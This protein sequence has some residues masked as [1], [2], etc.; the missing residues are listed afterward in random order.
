MTR[1]IFDIETNGLL[2]EL[3]TVHSLVIKDFDTG[4][5]WSFK[6]NVIQEGLNL[7][8][9]ADEIIG[10]NI[11][12][13]DIPALQKLN[14]TFK[15]KGRA[16]D[17]L[18]LTRLFWPEIRDTDVN[19]VKRG[20]IPSKL[21]GR[22]SL[23]AYGYRLGKWK[24]DYSEVMKARGLDPWASWSQEMQDYCVQDVEVNSLLYEKCLKVWEGSDKNGLNIPYSDQ[25]VFL[26]LRVA[27]ILTRQEK[28]GFA[29]DV[30][31]AEKF[32]TTLIKEREELY[33]SLKKT[34]GSWWA[35]NGKTTV[36]KTRNV[37]RKDLPPIGTRLKRNGEMEKLYVKETYLEGSSHTKIKLTEFNPASNHHVADRLKKLRN[38][39][40]TEFTPSGDVKVDE[41]ILSQLVWPEAKLLTRYLTVSKRISQLAEGTQA[42]LKKERNGRIHG[43]V[44]SLGAVTRR[45]THSNPNV[46]QVP[47]VGS[48]FGAECRE[49]FTA[50]KGYVLVGCDADALELRCLAGYMAAYDAGEYIRTVLSGDK[51]VGTDM[52]SVN[53]R[54]LGLDPKKTYQ[55]D[56]KQ[57]DGRDIAK[58]WFYAFI[59]GA[60]DFKLGSVLGTQG[61][62]KVISGA[63]KA[64]RERFLTGLPALGKLV[65]TVQKRAFGYMK[66]VKDLSGQK[67]KEHV[68]GRGFVVGLD[69]GK[70]KVR[71]KHAALNTLLQSA[72]AIIM[73]KALIILDDDLQKEGLKPQIDYEFA[74]NIHDEWQLDVRQEHAEKISKIAEDSIRKAGEAFKFACPL[75]GQAAIGKNWKETH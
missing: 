4:Q 27:E 72:G 28:W 70:I 47:K 12:K 24:G 3:T 18:I 49:L 37:N 56:G 66:T 45:M 53:S 40:P 52:H 46:A 2:E 23:E 11:I 60:G 19:L 58:T 73:K 55:V 25:S 68:K 10:H 54:A 8:Q 5:L 31:K 14:P 26:E 63:G 51:A 29:F 61:S 57:K 33:E 22:H 35:N 6:Q 30:K 16:I 65:E 1:L 62:V 71:H 67:R 7:L 64:S 32:Y 50:S 75:A 43:S 34:F 13:F 36:S 74:A 9:E 59:Y 21:I 20:I 17:T 44:I 48:H 15:P 42:W 39:Q 69:G 41:T 38:W